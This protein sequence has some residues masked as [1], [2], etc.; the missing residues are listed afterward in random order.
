MIEDQPPYASGAGAAPLRKADGLLCALR[1]QTNVAGRC[2]FLCWLLLMVLTPHS[3]RIGGPTTLVL[4]LSLAVAVQ[5][6][7]ISCL[8][9]TALKAPVAVGIGA[10]I[11]AA[12]WLIEYTGV[13]TG[14]PFGHYRYSSLLRPQIAS[15]P[16]QVPVAWLMML[17]PA[18]AV[19]AA[20]A[21]GQTK[22][23]P[24]RR[25]LND[26]SVA[27]ASGLAFTAWDLFLDPQMVAWGFWQWQT[28]GFYF[29]IPLVNFAGW[30]TA[31]SAITFVSMR[32]VAFDRLPLEALAIVYTTTWL[33]QTV[34]LAFFFDL[35]GPAAAGFL[36]MGVFAALAWRRLL[37]R[38][39]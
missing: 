33:L 32:M 37:D 29:G 30:A 22:T 6:A 14:L 15:V 35:P 1:L 28:P 23:D 13:S 27:L 4:V 9:S 3:S 25:W 19:G 38:S 10:A 26:L 18:W 5:A 12:T 8:L 21:S 16:V 36:G 20:V 34:G 31:A 11:L 2:L 7:L 24:S 39:E 17:P